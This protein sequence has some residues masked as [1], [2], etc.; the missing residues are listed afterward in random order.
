MRKMAFLSPIC[1]KYLLEA[2]VYEDYWTTGG[3]ENWLLSDKSN[4]VRPTQGSFKVYHP[5][6]WRFNLTKKTLFFWFFPILKSSLWN[7][8]RDNYSSSWKN[9]QFYP[10]MIRIWLI[11]EYVIHEEF[12][13][14]AFWYRRP[15]PLC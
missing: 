1:Q 7:P 12:K 8:E 2:D 4:L 5:S 13:N 15:C 14:G 3:A 10:I 11:S 9:V 6:K